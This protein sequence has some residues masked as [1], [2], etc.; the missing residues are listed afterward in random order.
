MP[1]VTLEYGDGHVDVDLPE[2][3]VVVRAGQAHPEPPP[4]ADPLQATRDAIRSPLGCAPLAEQVGPGSVVT[5]AFPDRVKGGSHATAHRKVALRVLLDELEAAGVALADVTLVCA[6]GLHRKNFRSEFEA[7]L[8]TGNL[9]RLRPEQVVNH[10]AEDPDGIVSLEQ[11]SLG[12][13]VQMNR[14]LAES[15]LTILIGHTAGNPYGGFS[16]GYKMPAT[17]LTTWRSIRGHHSPGSLYRDDF[18]PVSTH[19]HFRHQLASI[20]KRMETAMPRPFFTVDAVLDSRSRQ[21]GVYAGAISAVEKA[22]WPLATERTHVTLPGAPADILL[23][24]MPRSFHYGPGMGSNPVLMMQA[25]GSS[26]ARAKNALVP[27]PVVIAAAVCDGWFN[28]QDFP[29]YRA[30]YEALQTVPHPSDMV[31]HEEAMCTDYEWIH[32][33]REQHAYHPFHAF[34]MLYVGGLARTAAGAVYVAGARKPG[35]ARGMGAIP[36]ATVGHALAEA[37]ERVGADARI[38]VVP[39][40][41]QPA[42]H[43]SAA[44]R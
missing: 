41:S 39:E 6:V 1:S 21:L 11:S 9:A 37:R 25:I 29:S 35:Y 26:I 19:S 12:D 31:R 17:G 5:I 7:Y 42:Y 28:E 43:V 36:A 20:G 13:V 40:L 16:G 4:L 33:Y 3:A 30:A 24:G 18:L 34:S 15:D 10:D 14:R 2:N 32:R 27:H 22:S 8:G 44:G 23:L 38:L